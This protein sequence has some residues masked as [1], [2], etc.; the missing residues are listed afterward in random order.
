M[1][2]FSNLILN[3]FDFSLRLA[4]TLLSAVIQDLN[5]KESDPILGLGVGGRHCPQAGWTWAA[6]LTFCM[7]LASTMCPSPWGGLYFPQLVRICIL[8]SKIRVQVQILQP[9]SCAIL[10]RLLYLS[11]TFFLG[12]KKPL[13]FDTYQ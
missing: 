5:C 8:G 1:R 9:T 12:I 7:K 4:R 13:T 10:G 3:T 2:R 6:S 11:E